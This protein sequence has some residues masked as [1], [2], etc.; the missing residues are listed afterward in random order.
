MPQNLKIA[1]IGLGS[2]GTRHFHNII[3]QGHYALGF[4]PSPD[5]RKNIINNLNKDDISVN[6]HIYDDFNK[7]IKDCDAVIIANPHKYHAET[8]ASCVKE[9]KHC[10]VEKPIS[11]SIKDL[12]EILEE[13][14]KNNLKIGVGFNMRFRPVVV[15][16]QELIPNLGNILWARFICSSYLP[17]WRRNS[18]YSK[19]YTADSRTG[20]II[21]DISHELDL[22]S[23]LFGEAKVVSCYADNSKIL[24]I[25]SE[26][27]AN[28]TLKHES[29]T[30]S[31]IHLDYIT[32]HK[33]RCFE[34]AGKNGFMSVDLQKHKIT[35]IDNTGNI[36]HSGYY[37]PDNNNYEYVE[38][39]KNFISAIQGI[40]D[41]KCSGC[42]GYKNLQMIL[43][44]R[45]IAGLPS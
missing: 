6:A 1:V 23:Y 25:E 9:G 11:T 17:D 44:A 20:G 10:L 30:I 39:L 42:D 4:D 29:C 5:A 26:D 41:I 43:K 31:N 13:G 8:L 7:C 36:E 18:N 37:P 40:S 14:A 24:D 3:D 22:A 19:N 34:C 35:I 16:A 33:Q 2:I 21:F 45:L 27:I 15:K 38:E 32:R 12:H 28:I